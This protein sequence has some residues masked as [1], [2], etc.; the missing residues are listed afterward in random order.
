MHAG[1][2]CGA[3]ALV[4]RAQFEHGFRC[5][6]DDE[7]GAFRAGREHRSEPAREVERLPPGQRPAL[8][9]VGPAGDE[10][11]VQRT[12]IAAERCR[13]GAELRGPHIVLAIGVEALRE[14]DLGRGQRARLVRA[15]HGH[16][17]EIMNRGK[18]LHDNLAAGH[19]QRAARQRHR[20]DHRQQLRR[21][22]D[23]ER[24]REQQ[25]VQHRAAEH[26]ADGEH[27]Q[28]QRQ[29]GARD[30]EAE[31][32]QIALERGGHLRFGKRGRRRSEH[33]VAAGPDHERD[34]LAGLRH[35]A[36]EQRIRCVVGVGD[37]AGVLLRRIGLAGER[38]FARGEGRAL[39]DQ[40]IRR[41]DVAGTDAQDVAGHDLVDVDLAEGAVALDLGLER[42]R[43]A[44]DFR[45][46]DRMALLD[47]VEPD[48]EHED[49]D[50]DEPA[51]LV[52]GQHRDDAGHQQDQRQRLEQPA[53][54]RAHRALDARR[55]VAVGS[56]AVEAFGRLARGQA[57]QPAAELGAEIVG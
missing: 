53:Q 29:R 48:R 38:R 18:P 45:G 15:Q 51:D 50:D 26:D 46:A 36:A 13:D 2:R 40:R 6:L 3:R 41:N 7:Q 54:D 47:G 22:P 57:L 5:A 12:A 10:G 35:G 23:R 1:Q 25:R 43:A 39:Q 19:A 14:R 37:R 49:Q 33:G 55:R 11:S 31:F 44:E 24:D 9:G 21:Q 4:H 52:A 8:G 27:D 32:A 56:D 42:D 34:R 28:H 30:H 16:G 20:G 17:A